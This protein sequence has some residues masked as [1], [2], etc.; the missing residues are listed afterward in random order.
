MHLASC[1]NGLLIAV[2]AMCL[3]GHRENG[4]RR[5]ARQFTCRGGGWARVLC[6]GVRFPYRRSM[7]A[8]MC[9][10]VWGREAH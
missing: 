3:C 5:Q 7:S 1:L 8:G 9:H 10:W 2:T 6:F 4:G